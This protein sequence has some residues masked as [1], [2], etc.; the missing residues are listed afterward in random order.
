[1][2]KALFI[3]YAFPPQGGVGVQRAVKF[4]KYLPLYGYEC[5]VISAK[6]RFCEFK[7]KDLINQLDLSKVH[8]HNVFSFE[9]ENYLDDVKRSGHKFIRNFFRLVDFLFV[10]DE[11]VFWI[12]PVA[13]FGASMVLKYNIDCIF[14][15]GDP[16]SSLL[17]GYYISKLTGRP[18]IVDF[19]D[20]WISGY[21]LNQGSPRYRWH[22][23]AQ[24][25]MEEKVVNYAHKVISVTPSII[26]NFIKKYPDKKDKFICIPNGFDEDDFKISDNNGKD[27]EKF[28]ILHSG[29]VYNLRSPVNFLKSLKLIEKENKEMFDKIKV[30]FAGH[31]EDS[32]KNDINKLD[33]EKT[34]EF[35]GFLPH[36]DII[37]LQNETDLNLLILDD[38]PPA[39]RVYTAKIFEY[40]A[41]AANTLVIAP[42]NTEVANLIYKSNTGIVIEDRNDT[43]GIKEA[44]S[45]FI[46]IRESGKIAFEHNTKFIS[47][48]SRRNL[49]KQ[50]AEVFDESVKA[51]GR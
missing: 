15:T 13:L 9:P 32:V 21:L 30:I 11:K 14:A 29:K 27:K 28:I 7:D 26:D 33:M 45:N 31:V 17:A 39:K 35:T 1:M 2:K 8:L 4:L 3:S 19:R 25:A 46:N 48:F 38:A 37:K 20:E 10:P 16:F 47:Q 49:A 23:S 40:L 41:S 50:L 34:V 6:K 42:S 18:L 43:E 51:K 36:K 22:T 24:K 5:H 12:M 44:V